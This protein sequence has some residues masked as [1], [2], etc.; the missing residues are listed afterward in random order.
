MHLFAMYECA[1]MSPRAACLIPTAYKWSVKNKQSSRAQCLG[2]LHSNFQI[3]IRKNTHWAREE[4]R[5][6]RFSIAENE[7]S[8][9]NFGIVREFLSFSRFIVQVSCVYRFY[10]VSLGSLRVKNGEVSMRHEWHLCISTSIRHFY[11][12]SVC[13]ACVYGLSLVLSGTKKCI[14]L[15]SVC[16][17]FSCFFLSRHPHEDPRVSEKQK[18]KKERP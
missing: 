11:S 18:I 5:K 1:L 14:L 10:F 17:L 12:C 2:R 3:S 4:W 16:F 6:W 9:G 7:G 8:I 13:D 15:C